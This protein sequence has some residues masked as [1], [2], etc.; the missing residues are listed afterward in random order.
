V[1]ETTSFSGPYDGCQKIAP[2]IDWI[3]DLTASVKV[4]TN[5]RRN[6]KIPILSAFFNAKFVPGMCSVTLF[7]KFFAD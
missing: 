5:Q 1:G 4:F 2:E 7:S 6:R 3:V